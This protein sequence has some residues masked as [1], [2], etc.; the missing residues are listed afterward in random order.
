MI[1]KNDRINIE[2]E[3]ARFAF[4]H[5]ESPKDENEKPLSTNYDAMIKKLPAYIQTNGFMYTIAYLAE[6]DPGVLETIRKWLCQTNENVLRINK[7]EKIATNED[8]LKATIEK[9]S[10][11]EIRY[12]TL[13]TLALLGWL[14]RF[15]KDEDKSED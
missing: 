2:R 8:F 13:D 7:L 11:E 1:E 3:R 5:K 9:I 10:D 15:V 14:R 4:L 6:K 12:L